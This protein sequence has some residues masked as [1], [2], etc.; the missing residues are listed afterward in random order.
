MRKLLISMVALLTLPLFL[1]NVGCT[2]DEYADERSVKLEFS[3]DTV[4]FDT[5]F[6]TMGT[7]TRQLRVY[8]RSNRDIEIGSVTLLHGRNSRFRLNVDGDT[9]MVARRIE[10]Q[11]G[12]SLFIF[13]QACI[14]PNSS[15][16]PFLRTDS[17]V[18]SNGQF[19]TL[20]AY[21]RNAVYHKVDSGWF[22]RIDCAAWDHQRP[23]VFLGPAAVMEGNT[24]T[25]RSGD[26]LYFAD[27]AMLIIDSM[28]TLDAR[29]TAE[30]PIR[31]TSLRQEEWYRDMPGQ[32]QFI[33]FYNYSTANV[34]DHAVIE[35]AVAGIRCH[36][37]ASLTVSNTRIYNMSD[38]GIIGQNGTIIGSNL[39]VYDCHASLALI[40]GG[41]YTFTQSTF[42]DYWNY[43]GKLR[44][45]ASVIISNYYLTETACVAADMQRANF[46]DCII[47]GSRSNEV[48]VN[49]LAPFAMHYSF[50]HSLVRGGEWDEDP[51]FEDVSSDDYRLKEDSPAQGIGYNFTP[52]TDL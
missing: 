44:D 29:G 1:L 31:F 28:A 7:A 25:L 13:I 43:R 30:R 16:E 11:A 33:W 9:S 5:V 18:F 3:T 45:T 14:D 42:A 51:L 35:N 10:L 19:V 12:D 15:T 41:N 36:E 22:S 32:W 8:N 4:S 37:G 2:D 17:I 50:I 46:T 24:L 6:T 26:E 48:S 40:C 49:P 21:G 47:Y 34:I 27:G 38:A 20:N 23:H 52:T 39:L